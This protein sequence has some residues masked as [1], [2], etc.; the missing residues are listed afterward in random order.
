MRTI[1]SIVFMLLLGCSHAQ[2]TPVFDVDKYVCKLTPA[3][4]RSITEHP[5]LLADDCTTGPK[6]K[7]VW[8]I[9]PE[10]MNYARMHPTLTE[11]PARTLSSLRLCEESNLIKTDQDDPI[12]THLIATHSN[13]WIQGRVKELRDIRNASKPVVLPPKALGRW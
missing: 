12:W 5:I 2:Q 10:S 4:I 11:Y 8:V 9:S 3:K 13:T 7:R 6:L 1:S